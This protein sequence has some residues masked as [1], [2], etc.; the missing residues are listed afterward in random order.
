MHD[1]RMW[2]AAAAAAL[3]VGLF[4]WTT[5]SRAQPAGVDVDR[6]GP[7][8]GEQV[9]DFTGRDQQGRTQTLQ[10]LMGREGLMLVFSRSA[11]W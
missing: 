5:P 9:P 11:D 7:Q 10:S 8:V 4:S 1:T 3:L 6:I 2:R